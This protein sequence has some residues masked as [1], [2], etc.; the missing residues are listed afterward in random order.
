MGG[1]RRQ[2][3]QRAETATQVSGE[4]RSTASCVATRIRFD[5]FP[6]ESAKLFV[7]FVNRRDVIIAS[8]EKSNS[9]KCSD[10]WIVGQKRRR[11][12]D[13]HAGFSCLTQW[14]HAD[15]DCDCGALRQHTYGVPIVVWHATAVSS[16]SPPMLQRSISAQLAIGPML[17][18]PF[19]WTPSTWPDSGSL[20]DPPVTAPASPSLLAPMPASGLAS[21]WITEPPTT[22]ES[23]LERRIYLTGELPLGSGIIAAPRE[24]GQPHGPQGDSADAADRRMG[25]EGN[26]RNHNSHD[27]YRHREN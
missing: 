24:P 22:L 18:P 26:P 15:R 20:P 19:R 4:R 25:R 8:T 13:D 7:S 3:G 14:S 16:V 21:L 9:L 5:S 1:V 11:R 23:R 6:A 10:D 27:C 17:A 12:G 2:D